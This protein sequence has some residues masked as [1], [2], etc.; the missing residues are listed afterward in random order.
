MRAARLAASAFLIAACGGSDA[1]L[2]TP[3]PGDVA[4]DPAAAQVVT[5]DLV[6]FWAAYDAGGKSGSASEFQSKYLDAASSGLRDF[7]QLRSLTASSV[8]QM[9]TAYPRYF[10]SIRAVNLAFATDSTLARRIRA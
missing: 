1:T 7:I 6:H 9:V 5:S 4:I 2:P 10:A 8:S 3:G